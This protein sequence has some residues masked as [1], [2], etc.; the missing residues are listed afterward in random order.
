[1]PS[2]DIC[3]L[4]VLH[5]PVL[6]FQSTPLHYMLRAVK[7]YKALYMTLRLNLGSVPEAAYV[8]IMSAIITAD[9]VNE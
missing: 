8:R 3:G 6:H 5:F 9:D 7:A 1:M 2:S 4:L